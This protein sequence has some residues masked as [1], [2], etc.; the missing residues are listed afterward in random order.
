M[1]CFAVWERWELQLFPENFSKNPELD[2]PNSRIPERE[3]AKSQCE[4]FTV[5][6]V[7]YISTLMTDIF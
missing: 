7:Y 3:N 4:S 5:S 6:Q 2:T 1:C